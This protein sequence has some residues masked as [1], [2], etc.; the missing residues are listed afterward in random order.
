MVYIVSMSENFNE[1]KRSFFR[2][3]RSYV[4]HMGTFDKP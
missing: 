1:E 2:A 3:Y 4:E